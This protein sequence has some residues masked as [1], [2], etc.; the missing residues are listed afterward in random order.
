MFLETD[1]GG[2]WWGDSINRGIDVLGA[3][4]SRSQYVSPDD[5]RY[6]Q[7]RGGYYPQQPYYEPRGVSVQGDVNARGVNA[8]LN[9]STNTLLLVGLGVVVFMLGT[10]RGRG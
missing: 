1:S 5:P 3:W 2:P 9:I 4:A 7:P 10:K 8:G 6:R